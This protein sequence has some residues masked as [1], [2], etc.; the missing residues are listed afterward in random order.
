MPYP[1]GHRTSWQGGPAFIPTQ[2][3]L[4]AVLGTE[5][6]TSH[7]L[8]KNHATR[9]NSQW[10]WKSRRPLVSPLASGGR[11]WRKIDDLWGACRG[12]YKSDLSTV[13]WSCSAPY[14]ARM[15]LQGTL[16]NSLVLAI[17]AMKIFALTTIFSSPGETFFGESLGEGRSSAKNGFRCTVQWAKLCFK[18][19]FDFPGKKRLVPELS[20]GQPAK[21]PSRLHFSSGT[22]L[23]Q[24]WLSVVTG[25]AEGRGTE[26]CKRPR[27]FYYTVTE[28]WSR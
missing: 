23:G 2:S 4:T 1:L 8:S 10:M 22:V 27:S 11:S 28:K 16:E 13:T 14:P 6:T 25:Q 19:A 9:S 17:L 15:L 5:P 26:H 18:G 21:V 12:V 20:P 7:T 24:S 3:W